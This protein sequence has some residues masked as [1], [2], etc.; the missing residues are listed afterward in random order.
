MVGFNFAPAGW[1]LCNGQ[2][3]SISQNTALFSLLGTYYGGNGTTTFALPNLQS[4]VPIHQGQGTGLSTYTLGQLGGNETTTLLA[5]NLPP[6]THPLL[7]STATGTLTSPAGG[8]IAQIN[9]GT[10]RE[11]AL[12]M[13]Y[14]STAP[15]TTMAAGSVGNNSSGATPFSTQQ[16]YLC[17]NFIIAL[18]GIYP[19]RS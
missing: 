11:P 5:T 8:S 16:P 12:A 9:A 1:A 2:L 18:E 3:L 4:R 14:A 13:G 6:H 17:I 7:G 15:N 10:P 19:S